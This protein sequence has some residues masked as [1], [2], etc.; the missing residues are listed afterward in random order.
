MLEEAR[1]PED[2]PLLTREEF[3]GWRKVILDGYRGE[4]PRRDPVRFI[5]EAYVRAF[6]SDSLALIEDVYREAVGEGGV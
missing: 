3:D 1:A 2:H 5:T 6:A 4:C